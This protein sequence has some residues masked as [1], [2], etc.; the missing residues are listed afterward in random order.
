TVSRALGD[1]P[2]ARRWAER[3]SEYFSGQVGT[4]KTDQPAARLGWAQARTMLEDYPTALSILEAGWN[5]SSSP[6]YGPAIGQVCSD[7]LNATNKEPARDLTA[8]L[9]LVQKGLKFAPQNMGLIQQLLDITHR[10]GGEAV[11]ARTTLNKLLAEGG[12]SP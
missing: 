4:A 3:A 12:S 2:E 6:M 8:R 1:E 5:Q 9:K 11:T 7:W 10:E